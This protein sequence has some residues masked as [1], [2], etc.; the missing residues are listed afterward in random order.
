MK[1]NN[2]IFTLCKFRNQMDDADCFQA[3]AL[4]KSQVDLIVFRSNSKA[5]FILMHKKRFKNS[6]TM[7]HTAFILSNTTIVIRPIKTRKRTQFIIADCET[8]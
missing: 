4:Q 3:T 7:I 2:F 5:I 1:G 8:S 6:H